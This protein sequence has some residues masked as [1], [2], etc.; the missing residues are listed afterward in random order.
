LRA[1]IHVK[2]TDSVGHLNNASNFLLQ[3]QVKYLML[4]PSPRLKGEKDWHKYEKAR[5]LGEKIGQ[6]RENYKNDLKSKKMGIRQRAVA[7]YFI[8][9]VS[10]FYL[11]F[12]SKYIIEIRNSFYQTL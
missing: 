2:T 10:S 11:L 4:N 7:M 12:I 9:E 3:G 5:D 1:S 6:I 8:D